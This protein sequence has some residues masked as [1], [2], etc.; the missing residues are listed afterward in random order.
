MS[1]KMYGAYL[2]AFYSYLCSGGLEHFQPEDP[3]SKPEV[4]PSIS[5]IGP[6]VF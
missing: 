2:K 6:V 5:K 3:V 4:E 1:V